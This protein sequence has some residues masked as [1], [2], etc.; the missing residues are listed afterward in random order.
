M[1]GVASVPGRVLSQDDRQARKAAAKPNASEWASEWGFK[2][3][4]MIPIDCLS[5]LFHVWAL[6]ERGNRCA[7]R[8]Q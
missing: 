3:E 7:Y 8:L 4:H 1:E 5:H 2:D 6:H